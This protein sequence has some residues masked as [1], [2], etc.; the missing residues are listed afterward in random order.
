MWHFFKTFVYSLSWNSKEKSWKEFDAHERKPQNPA[1]ENFENS[2]AQ[3]VCPMFLPAPG[4][5][6]VLKQGFVHMY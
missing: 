6:I 5:F 2:L 1:L 3:K 4:S